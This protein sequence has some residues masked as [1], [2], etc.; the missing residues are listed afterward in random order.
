MTNHSR[1]KI[2]NHIFDK[3]FGKLLCE[4]ADHVKQRSCATSIGEQAIF[5]LDMKTRKLITKFNWTAYVLPE[6]TEVLMQ[7]LTPI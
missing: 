7:S 1:K 6:F 4:K 3:Y 5:I 2:K